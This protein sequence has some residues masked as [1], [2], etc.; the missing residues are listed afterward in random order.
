M[1]GNG[2][3]D[4]ENISKYPTIRKRTITFDDVRMSEDVSETEDTSG[5]IICDSQEELDAALTQ[6]CQAYY[7]S[8]ADKPKVTI[9]ADMVVL[10]RNELYGGYSFLET[11]SLGDTVYCRHDKLDIATD[12]RV[13][14]LKYDSIRKKVSKVVIGD[15]KKDWFELFG[16]LMSGK[17]VSGNTSSNTGGNAG[18]N[19]GGNTG[20]DTGGSTTV[21][22]WERYKAV[23]SVGYTI[24][25]DTGVEITNNQVTTRVLYITISVDSTGKIVL[26]DALKESGSYGSEIV[27]NYQSYPFIYID[28]EV[29]K[30]TSYAS[31]GTYQGYGG[32]TERAVVETTASGVYTK[33]EY[34]GEVTSTIANTYPENG[35]QYGYW[36][37]KK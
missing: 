16:Y 28:G 2:Y 6:K 20:G 24:A 32:T 30:I 37:V 29:Y 23:E 15:F 14:E 36:Y 21:Y 5:L 22:T 25:Y 31:K 26:S 17:L 8:G 7:E 33:G 12:S 9:T 18:G 1:T 19:T 11:I 3:V 35:Y 4:S 34:I 13:I 10:K 27:A